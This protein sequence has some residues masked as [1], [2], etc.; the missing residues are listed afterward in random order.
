[1]IEKTG[2]HRYRYTFSK[3]FITM[4][5]NPAILQKILGHSSLLTTQNYL[6]ILVTDL[7]KEINQFNILEEFSNNDYIKLKG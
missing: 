5:G 7:K 2:V 3:K 1:M 6:N 4:G